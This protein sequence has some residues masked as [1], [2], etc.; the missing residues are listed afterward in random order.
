MSINSAQFGVG[1]TSY[2]MAGELAG[3]TALVDAF[4]DNMASLPEAEKIRGMHPSDLSLSRQKLVYFLSGWLGGP[5]LFAEHFG[6]IHIPTAHRH[7]AVGE[8]ERDA[9]MLCMEKAVDVQAYDDAF[10]TYLIE[11]LRIPAER[12]RQACNA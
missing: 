11:Q 12:I 7:L 4:Y 9:W 10:K 8:K 2:K 3:L 6:T 1:D 5:K